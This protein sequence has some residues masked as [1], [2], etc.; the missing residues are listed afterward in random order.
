MLESVLNTI[1]RRDS[2]SATLPNKS[3]HQGGFPVNTSELTV[4]LQQGFLLK[5]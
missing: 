1:A 4:L 2:R 5:Q 3:Y